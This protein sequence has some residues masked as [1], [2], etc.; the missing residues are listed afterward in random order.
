MKRVWIASV[1]M[2]LALRD[3]GIAQGKSSIRPVESQEAL[4][5]K[6]CSGCHS[7]AI[8]SGGFTWSAIDLSHPEQNAALAER[9]IR[10]IRSGMMPPS[11]APRPELA[12]LKS[13]ASALENSI[14]KAAGTRPYVKSPELHRMNRTEYQNAVRDL[15]GIQVDVGD[16]LPPDARTSSGVA[17]GGFDNMSEALTI[18]PSLLSAY[19]RA[20]DQVSRDAVGD[21]KAETA[22]TTYKVSRLI[23]QMR[24]VAGAPEGTRGGISVLHTFPADG[25]YTFKATFYYYYTEQLI[26]SSLPNELQNQQIEISVD[27]A[28]VAVMNIDPNVQE[29]AANY[30]TPPVKVRA[31]QR[32]LS[33]AFIAKF[34]GPV[35]D[36]NRLIENTI[37]DTTIS[38]T[39]EMTG[40]PHLQ[41]LA[42]T[43][44]FKPTG[45]SDNTSRSKIFSCRPAIPSQNERCASEIIKGL[46]KQAFRRPVNAEDLE[47]LMEFYKRGESDGGFDEGIRAAIQAILSKPEFVFRFE[48]KPA[49]LGSEQTYKISDLELASRL[50]YFLWSSIPDE[51]LLNLAGQNKLSDPLVLAQQVK[52]MLA[53]RRSEALSTNFAGQWLRLTGLKDYAPESLI[54]P[55]FTRQLS[56]SMRR[57]I[58]LLF[59]SIVRENRSVVDLLN[60]DYTF[61]DETLARHYGIPN[62]VGSDFRR[63]QLTDPNRFG[64]LG[65]AGVLTVTSLANRTSPVARGKYVLE[66]LM[67]ISPPLP[68]PVVPP[69]MEQV[70]NQKVLTVRERME[71][72]RANGACASCHRIMDPIGL[73]LDNFDA[74]GSWRVREGETRVD[75]TGVLYDGSK[76]DGPISL[77]EAV[78]KRSDAF[79]GALTEN[80]LTFALGRVLDYRDMP[81]VRAITRRAAQDNYRFSDFVMGIVKSPEFLMR[82]VNAST[83]ENR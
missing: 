81:A 5:G 71:Q 57:E 79:V 31:G 26:G 32:R 72:H 41:A 51:Q 53:D 75:P 43:G 83:V 77:R 36:H 21:P 14:D 13:F 62:V 23:N 49:S 11:G 66:V 82:S 35:Q 29:S 34:D 10:K 58:E 2:V 73:S 27:G 40:L 12:T 19:V 17:G 8:K 15:L 70:D 76:L 59:D 20:A 38:I 16:L 22:M 60:A 80:L 37:L 45:V 52:R 28:R 68:P 33:A 25:E 78:M 30:V 7:D 63:V 3:S 50:A 69:L 6:Y 4:V 9:I 54:F 44:P 47:S 48:K 56:N 55:D 67:G 24:Q 42:V 65:K 18:T 39:P 1:F 64:L 46:A 74:V 61:V